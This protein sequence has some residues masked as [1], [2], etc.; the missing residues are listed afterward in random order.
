MPLKWENHNQEEEEK[1]RIQE[2]L[3]YIAF[4]VGEEIIY[5]QL[6]GVFSFIERKGRFNFVI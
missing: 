1:K 3:K 6:V 2:I 5:V 4:L